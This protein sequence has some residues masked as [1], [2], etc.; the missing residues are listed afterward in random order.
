MF[1]AVAKATGSAMLTAP[2][3]LGALW[4]A[5]PDLPPVPDGRW[6]TALYAE[7][8]ASTIWGAGFGQRNLLAENRRTVVFPSGVL[9]QRD[10]VLNPYPLAVGASLAQT[11][12]DRRQFPQIL[13]RRGMGHTVCWS[14]P[15]T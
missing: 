3:E 7:P 12:W 2:V 13:T 4:A 5:I 14:T 10:D 8:E 15:P 1:P 6:P 11:S 9:L